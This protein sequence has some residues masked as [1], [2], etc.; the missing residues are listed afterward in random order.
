[1]DRPEFVQVDITNSFISRFNPKLRT[2]KVPSRTELNRLRR[3][4][5]F[6]EIS[7]LIAFILV[8]IT[9][10]SLL[11]FDNK[12]FGIILLSLNIPMNLYPALLQ[13]E[14]KLRIDKLL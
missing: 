1:M 5:T 4:M 9:G 10:L 2:S 12:Q 7:H 6:S 3:E 14:N 11:C 13:Q 8:S